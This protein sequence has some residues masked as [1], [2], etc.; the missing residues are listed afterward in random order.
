MKCFLLLS[1][2]SFV[3]FCA[4]FLVSETPRLCSLFKG[5][6][7]TLFYTSLLSHH[8]STLQKI[9]I[10]YLYFHSSRIP[11]WLKNNNKASWNSN[12]TVPLFW[13]EKS[14]FR[15]CPLAS[16]MQ[17]H[18]LAFSLQCNLPPPT[19]NSAEIPRWRT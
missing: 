15:W 12:G 19:Q 10:K 13:R 18:L 14:C 9:L 2:L 1:F 6:L 17:L 11:D 4:G 7:I 16:F 5:K 8:Y 3:Y